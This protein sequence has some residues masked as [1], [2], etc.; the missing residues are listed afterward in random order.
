MFLFE[1]L[2]QRVKLPLLNSPSTVR[3]SAP[4]A[5]TAKTVQDFTVF[6]SKKDRTSAA[7]AGVATDVRAGQP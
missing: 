7:V 3:S 1:A 2:L 6:P 4:S 5:C